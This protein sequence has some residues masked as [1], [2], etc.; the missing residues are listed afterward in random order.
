MWRSKKLLLIGGSGQLGQALV[1]RF[2]KGPSWRQWSIFNIDLEPNPLADNNFVLDPTETI[3]KASVEELH[4][5]IKKWDDEVEAIINVA[6]LNYPPNTPAFKRLH[7]KD[8]GKDEEF[9]HPLS[10]ASEDCFDWYSKIQQAEF[11]PTMLT[12]N[13]AGEYLAPTGYVV[14]TGSK[15]SLHGKRNQTA[16]E[17]VAKSTVA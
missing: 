4:K 9:V 10:V 12:V 5:E 6:G 17:F 7:M 15:D 13:L 2:K 11:I 14:F 1:K 16:L 3:S 8:K